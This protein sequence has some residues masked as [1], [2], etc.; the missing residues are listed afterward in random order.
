VRYTQDQLIAAADAFA[1]EKVQ[2]ALRALVK[3]SIED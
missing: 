3:R 2:H 1:L